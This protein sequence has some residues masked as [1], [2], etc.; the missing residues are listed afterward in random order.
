MSD[1]PPLKYILRSDDSD[2][3]APLGGKARALA[4]L[5]EAGLSIPPWFVLTPAAFEASLEPAQYAALCNASSAAALRAAVDFLRPGAEV[6]G[7]LRRAVRE[8]CPDGAAVAVRS[9][10]SDEDGPE[11]SFAG[12]LD[13]FLTVPP[14]AVAGRVAAVWRSGFSERILAYRREHQLSPVPRPPAVLVQ[15]LVRADVS[16]VA[17]GADPVSGRRSV[18]VVAAI[19]GLGT[20]LV[21]G[22]CDADTFH[23]DRAGTIIQRTLADKRT[24]HRPAAGEGEGVR[25]EAVAADLASRPAL[26][27]E[28]VRQVADLVRQCGKHFGRPQDIEWAIERGNLYLLQSRPI[29]SLART[30]DPDGVLNLWDNSNI[31]ES[32]NGVTTPLTF[33]FAR[34]I[35]EGVYRQF[36]KILRVPPARLAENDDVFSHMLG[37][38][39]GRVY[40]NLLSWYRVLALLPG[41][42]TNRRFM[43]QMMGVKEPLP[44]ELVANLARSTGLERLQDRWHLLGSVLALVRNH[45]TLGGQIRR[46]YWRLQDALGAAGRTWNRCGRTSWRRS[47]ATWSGGC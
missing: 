17:F 7:E 3:Q 33:S 35:Y 1:H 26:S 8:L 39:R 40:Y 20:A 21:S 36:C 14:E 41:F 25:A 47:T 6:A 27:D 10:A 34:C 45:F 11:H 15:R 9:S 38:V 42:K 19:Y 5:R 16:G 37:L 12:Q 31:A 13:S 18:A 24:A 22:A 2:P 29:T 23:V 4:A 44:D 43:E 32:Y 28:Q 46:F 30:A